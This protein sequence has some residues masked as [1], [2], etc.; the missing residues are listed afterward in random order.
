MKS[1]PNIIAI[2][3][4]IVFLY[5]LHINKLQENCLHIVGLVVRTQN[6]LYKKMYINEH[7]HACKLVCLEKSIQK[8]Y[9]I[10][11][12]EHSEDCIT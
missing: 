7:N 1:L 8:V 6:F 4:S 2:Q 12:L 3:Y 10:A 9:E 5:I 11:N